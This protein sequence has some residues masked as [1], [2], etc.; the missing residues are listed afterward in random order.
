MAGMAPISLQQFLNPTTGRAYAG[1]RANFYEASTTTRIA[2]YSD[3]G[4]SQEL[5]NPVIADAYGRFPAIFLDEETEFYRLRLTSATGSVLPLGDGGSFDLPIL[6]IIGPAVG[7][8]GEVTVGTSDLET[9]DVIWSPK[10]GTRARF[11][12]LNGRTIGSAASG[13]TERANADC[14]DLY[15]FCWNEFSDTLAPVTGGR[16]ASALAD[17][18]ANKPLQ[19]LNG[20]NAL[21]GGMSGM[22]NSSSSA[23]SALTFTQGD[24]TT[25][26]SI[27]GAPTVTI[28]LANLPAVNLS[29]DNLVLTT[30]LDYTGS[31]LTQATGA[32][33][34]NNTT[35][36]GAANTAIT[37]ETTISGTLPLGGSG[38]ALDK[39]PKTI[40]GTFYQKL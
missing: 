27:L 40:L 17:F 34:L 12:R 28:A 25:A 32:F 31:P 14:E 35:G 18:Q 4:L 2:V 9:G 6:P 37:A 22:G 19:L 38:A 5:P 11:V 3:Y 23:F 13:A 21:L 8:E 24:E 10:S 39:M 30:E 7:G 33:Q 36:I 20:R 16:G 29:L 26:G 15:V 1:A